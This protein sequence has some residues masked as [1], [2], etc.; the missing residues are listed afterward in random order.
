MRGSFLNNNVQWKVLLNTTVNLRA[1][2][3]AERVFTFPETITFSGGIVRHF[4]IFFNCNETLQEGKLTDCP[5][6]H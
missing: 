2:L 4:V 1:S 3:R 6:V 5:A